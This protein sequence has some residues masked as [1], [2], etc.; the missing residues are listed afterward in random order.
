MRVSTDGSL[1]GVFVDCVVLVLNWTRSCTW[2]VVRSTAVVSIDAHSA[3]AEIVSSK[4]SSVR[5]V[6]WDLVVIYPKTISLGIGVVEQS[7]LEHLVH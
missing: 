1:D 7:A 3:V 2:F 4:T 6:D 5:A